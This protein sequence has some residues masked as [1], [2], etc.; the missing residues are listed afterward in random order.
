MNCCIILLLLL[1]CN[2]NGF[3]CHN[4][5]DCGCEKVEPRCPR[6][7]DKDSCSCNDSRFEPRFESRPFGGSTCGCEEQ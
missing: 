4:D 7:S 6:E 1:F 5:N 3:G 2:Q